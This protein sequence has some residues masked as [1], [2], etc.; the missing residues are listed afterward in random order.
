[1]LANMMKAE[2]EREQA[3]RDTLKFI[4]KNFDNYYSS[5]SRAVQCLSILDVLVSFTLYVKN[6]EHEMCRPQLV[7]LDETSGPTKPFL[8]IKNG[9][10]PCL[11]KTFSGDFIPNDLLIG[12]EV[13]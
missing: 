6:S 8:D 10:H 12:C 2:E 11:I 5:W 13:R 1:M 7:V 9:R 3:L 4:F